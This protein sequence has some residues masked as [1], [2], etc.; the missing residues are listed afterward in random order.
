MVLKFDPHIPDKRYVIQLSPKTEMQKS[1]RNH[2]IIN[3]LQNNYNGKL[4]ARIIIYVIYVTKDMAE[5]KK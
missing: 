5:E 3:I 2:Y 1:N 4:M